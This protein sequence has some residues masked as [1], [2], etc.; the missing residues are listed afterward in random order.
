MTSKEPNET[1][2]TVLKVPAK[3]RTVFKLMAQQDGRTMA[4]MF[5]YL[6][7]AEAKRRRAGSS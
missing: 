3:V 6:V 5:T 7:K 1:V 4:G 2:Q